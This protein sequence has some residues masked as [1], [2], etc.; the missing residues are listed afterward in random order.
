MEDKLL[1]KLRSKDPRTIE[2]TVKE[3]NK[4][5]FS[6]IYRFTHNVDDTEDV[7]QEVWMKFMNSLYSFQGRSSIYTYLYRI[8]VNEAL[9]YLRKNKFK[10]FLLPFKEPR[11]NETPESLYMEK[12]EW[13]NI[14]KAVKKLPAKQKKVFI[15]RNE[16][17]PFKEISKIL[18]IKENNAKTLYFYSLKN[19]KKNLKEKKRL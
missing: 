8:A 16:N 10:E 12:E 18:E 5:L 13:E 6:I 17:M 2:N 1:E 19:I 11:D 3:Y 9:M 15:L 14:R 7:L 4:R